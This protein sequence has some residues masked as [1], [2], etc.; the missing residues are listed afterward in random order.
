MRNSKYVEDYWIEYFEETGIYHLLFN[1]TERRIPYDQIND[2]TYEFG[3]TGEEE[4]LEEWYVR[5][6]EIPEFLPKDKMYVPTS[7][8]NKDQISFYFLPIDMIRGGKVIIN[9]KDLTL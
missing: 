4:T 5:I 6:Q 1:T 2:D 7:I 3:D 9:S 8:Q